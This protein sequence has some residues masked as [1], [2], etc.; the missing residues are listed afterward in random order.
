MEHLLRDAIRIHSQR[1]AD[2]VLGQADQ[3]SL[4]LLKVD[5]CGRRDRCWDELRKACRVSIISWNIFDDGGVR[6]D[7]CGGGSLRHC[8]PVDGGTCLDEKYECERMKQKQ[9]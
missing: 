5:R 3:H 7:Y 1:A 6:D 4:L 9:N 2:S 8:I